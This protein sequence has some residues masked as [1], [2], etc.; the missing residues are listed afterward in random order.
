MDSKLKKSQ[1][2]LYRSIIAPLLLKKHLG[3]YVNKQGV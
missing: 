3:Q 1:G 2:I